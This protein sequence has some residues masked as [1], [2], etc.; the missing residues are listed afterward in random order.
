MR[1]AL[2]EAVALFGPMEWA[3]S[4]TTERRPPFV[5]WRFAPGH[6]SDADRIVQL[7]GAFS[8]DVEWCAYH[9][10]RNWVIEPKRVRDFRESGDFRTDVD[11]A[12]AFT[13]A[14]PGLV[15]RMHADAEVLA[16]ELR[17]VIQPN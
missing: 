14:N 1:T 2:Y 6:E 9:E 15:E 16:Q 3:R 7:V 5:A 10:G 13:A 11:A 12:D 17:R 8:G 4:G